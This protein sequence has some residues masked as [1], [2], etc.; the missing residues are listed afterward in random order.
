[1]GRALTFRDRPPQVGDWYRL[2]DANRYRQLCVTGAF[3]RAHPSSYW[4]EAGQYYIYCRRAD[5]GPVTVGEV[6]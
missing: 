2:A 4:A 5:G 6:E 3:L 1:M